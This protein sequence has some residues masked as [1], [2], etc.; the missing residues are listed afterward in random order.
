[1]ELLGPAIYCNV[2]FLHDTLIQPCDELCRVLDPGWLKA[3]RIL[4][5]EALMM[6]ITGTI[7]LL[8][9]M[10]GFAFA[11]NVA[12]PEIDAAAGVGALTLLSGALLVIRGRK[13]R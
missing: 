1:M 7:L 9:G 8:M 11:G 6:K 12:T 4:I 5:L 2:L 3:L 13:K 10:A